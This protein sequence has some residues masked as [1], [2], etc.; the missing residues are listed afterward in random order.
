MYPNSYKALMKTAT[1]IFL[2][3]WSISGMAQDVLTAEA[4]IRIGLENNYSIRIAR[5]QARI[6]ANNAG[7]GTANLLPVV[8][9]TG[10]VQ[11]ARSDVETNSPFSFGKS[12]TRSGD[13]QITLTWTLFDG[14]RMFA[15]KKRFEELARLG[16]YQARNIIE[17][18]VVGILQAYFNLVQQEMLLDVA[19]QSVEISRTRLEKEQMKH[20]MGALSSTDLLN[21][22]VAFNN[23]RAALLNQEVQ[24]LIARKNLN[25]ALAQDPATPIT[26]TREI[27]IPP[28]A[29]E[30]ETLWELAQSHNAELLAAEQN[31]RIARENLKLA[32]AAFYPRLLL[33][34]TYGYTDRTI[35]SDS[36]RFPEDIRTRSTDG[37]VGLTLSF[38]LFN[39]FRHKIALQNARL[40]VRNQEL[41]MEDARN[42]L[43]GLL[44]EKYDTFQKQ[45]ELVALQ[46]ENVA[47]AR[48]QLEVF[49]ERYRLGAI[50]SLEFRDAQVS[51]I[52]AQ[53]NLIN[54]RYRARI[55]RLEIEQLIGRLRVD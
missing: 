42:R 43:R 15:D 46:Q 13:A 35:A 40:E 32:G 6:A 12:T 29:T 51:F 55:T 54:A 26:V 39:G 23:D 44:R 20:D 21:A 41:A 9:A 30:F 28:L 14:F 17:N 38:N 10:R 24:V 34:A 7:Q 45:V 27:L 25:L 16:E 36:P 8:D 49:Q 53:T 50:T 4:A 47:A 3:W 37:S 52:R 5:N 22:Q 2:L 19:R 18:T 1:M 33:N 11:I 31:H 48:Q